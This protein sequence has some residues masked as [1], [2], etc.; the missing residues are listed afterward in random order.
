MFSD[1]DSSA[2]RNKLSRSSRTAS[3]AFNI[4]RTA[5]S[6]ASGIPVN[7]CISHVRLHRETARA[8]HSQLH[9]KPTNLSINGVAKGQIK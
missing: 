3:H 8:C 2:K 4:S 6:P 1:D 9:G 5:Y 7:A